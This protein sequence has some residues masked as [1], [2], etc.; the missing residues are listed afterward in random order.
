MKASLRSHHDPRCQ[1]RPSGSR[2]WARS[3]RSSIMLA[4]LQPHRGPILVKPKRS[5][6][7]SRSPPTRTESYIQQQWRN[8]RMGARF[9]L[10]ML[11]TH[12]RIT[13]RPQRLRITIRP[14]NSSNPH[15][16]TRM[17]KRSIF[18][19]SPQTLKMRTR[20]TK[21]MLSRYQIGRRQDISRIS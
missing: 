16:N 12:Q 8:T 15:L 7:N 3:L 18:P 20:V 2:I 5:C 17:A 4:M 21:E 6:S 1:E 13:L 10:Q 9:R 14:S 11:P 19:K